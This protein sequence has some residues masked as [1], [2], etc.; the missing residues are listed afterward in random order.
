MVFIV[1]MKLLL[2]GSWIRWVKTATTISS[3]QR[4]TH[5]VST[6]FIIICPTICTSLLCLGNI[7]SKS[8]VTLANVFTVLFR[9]GLSL[10]VIQHVRL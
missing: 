6:I 10:D 3:D 7:F 8:L 2:T 1:T 4:I 5:T 9:V